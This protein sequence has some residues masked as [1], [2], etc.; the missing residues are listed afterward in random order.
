MKAIIPFLITIS[1]VVPSRAAD[2]PSRV[3]TGWVTKGEI[4]AGQKALL[5]VELYAPGYFD[6]AAVFDLPKIPHALVLPPVGSPVLDSKVIDGVNYTVQRHEL[7]VFAYTAGKTEV[8]AF[9]VR[10]AIKRQALDHDSVTQ[11]VATQPLTLETKAVPG[12]KLG[13]WVITSADLKV[14]ETWKP[15]PG[16]NEKT[17]A[18]FVRTLVWTASDVPGM[19]FPPFKED[20]IAGLGIYPA[21]PLV[22]DKSDRGDLLGQRTDTVT[23]VCK[24]GGI[25]TIPAR[26]LRWWDPVAEEMKRVDFP[27]RVIDVIAPPVPQPTMGEKFRRWMKEDW[28]VLALG[29]AGA[30]LLAW[31]VRKWGRRV[32]S[33]FLPTRLAELNPAEE[34]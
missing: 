32:W 5:A 14:E 19:A 26:H 1:I 33:W 16:K 8:P 10:F 2:P 6:G 22:E 25:V 3:Q 23:Y 34:R 30:V 9:K 12:V 31:G 24:A 17:G 29:L 4:W 27:A 13:E 18:A 21:D 20:P 28:K 7:E 11:E 15:E